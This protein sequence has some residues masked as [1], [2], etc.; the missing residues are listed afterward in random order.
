MGIR[1]KKKKKNRIKEYKDFIIFISLYFFKVI[2]FFCKRLIVIFWDRRVVF[3]LEFMEFVCILSGIFLVNFV[4]K[5][6]KIKL[7]NWKIIREKIFSI[8]RREYID[9]LI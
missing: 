1:I 2:L 6:L 4:F 3:L 8:L 9:V 7:R 5:R